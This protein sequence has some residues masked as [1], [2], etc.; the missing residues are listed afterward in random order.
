MNDHQ[1]HC[2]RN[3]GEWH[4]LRCVGLLVAIPGRLVRT[5]TRGPASALPLWH[6]ARL[7][8]RAKEP[9]RLPPIAFGKPYP[10]LNLI[11]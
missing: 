1:V 4:I 3:D 2:C 10:L 11:Y 5:C 7:Y 8:P 9:R 6:A